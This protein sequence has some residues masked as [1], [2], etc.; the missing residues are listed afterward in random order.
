[1]FLNYLKVGWRNLKG[2]KVPSIINIF[3]LSVA[4]AYSIVA[5]MF[6]SSKLYRDRFHTNVDNIYMLT[7]T[8]EVKGETIRYGMNA[9]VVGEQIQN[10]VSDFNRVVR[11][12]SDRALVKR[13]NDVF[14]ES[15]DFVDPG[16]YK[17]FDFPLKY[18]SIEELQKPDRIAITTW[19]S[20][21]YFGE[22]YPIGEQLRI[23][24]SGVVKTL[25]I[26]AIIEP[27]PENS[28]IDFNFLVNYDLVRDFYPG[29]Q[30]SA[31]VMVELD[32][33]TDQADLAGLNRL[34]DI[35]NELNT[36]DPYLAFQ[37]EPL[38]SI[39]T[40]SDQI[41]GGI[42][43][44]SNP[45]PLI[46]LSTIAILLLT[47]AIFNY[48][49]IAIMMASKRIKEIGTRKVMGAQR[50]QI[51]FQFLVENLIICFF[52]LLLGVYIA[53][54]FFIPWFNTLSDGA[55][56]I[57]FLDPN[58]WYF[59]TTV[60]VV[61]G[62]SSGA[63]PA[64]FISSFQP[65]LIFKG[66]NQTMKK[67][68]FSSLLLTIQ[69]S[70]A[71]ITI[72]AGSVIVQ[73]NRTNKERDWGYDQESKLVLNTPT[74]QDHRLLKEKI[75]AYPDV[76]SITGNTHALGSSDDRI[77]MK[78]GGENFQVDCL[79]G[80]D[81]YANV[82]GLRLE[83]GR[84]FERN[85]SSDK[86]SGLIVNATFM[87]EYEIDFDKQPNIT[88]D[89]SVYHIVGV[90]QDFHQYDFEREIAPTALMISDEERF[91]YLTM[92]VAPGKDL[93]MFE[94]IQEIYKAQVSDIPFYG[95]MQSRVFEDY[96]KGVKS[97]GDLLVF[98]SC[99]AIILS[100][101]G[102]YGLVSLIIANSMKVF[103]IKKVLG[104]NNRH[105]S[106]KLY[107]KFGIMLCI[108]AV[109]G[110]LI[111]MKAITM[112]LDDIYSYHDELSV[113]HIVGALLL[114]STVVLITIFGLMNKI[115]RTNPVDILKVD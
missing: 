24:I 95:Y 35:N 81:D 6:V 88:I 85:S 74:L 66:V 65:S 60:L 62:V 54:S 82:M 11:L 45:A 75:S 80:A 13:G 42:G 21:K 98:T 111:C 48:L 14:I 2:Q 91:G 36:E 40:N 113:L 16:F 53:Y 33:P 26:A 109:V 114:L 93:T 12:R 92:E 56:K 115:K 52:A 18:G 73:T 47:L 38:K 3:G 99:L 20:T 110:G 4:I 34:V 8:A 103:S 25:K 9:Q 22:E 83:K 41:R 43:H 108:S 30:V 97:V 112:L 29:H 105:L 78:I 32:Q 94:E 31:C 84:F 61:I 46:V 101:M 89:S 58:I 76:I 67:S 57:D 51:V 90:V 5:Y 1:M 106:A 23:N 17:M 50:N 71:L 102:L 55:H 44:G 7:H 70:L 37:L 59:L 79:E 19:T 100:A 64:W 68:G 86:A 39:N 49:N 63:Y 96:F 107:K 10:E 27:A 77:A 104:A 87:K 28:T 72:V 15:M 69:F